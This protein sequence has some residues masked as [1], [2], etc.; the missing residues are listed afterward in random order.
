[1]NIMKCLLMI[2]GL[3]SIYFG[4]TTTIYT[5]EGEPLLVSIDNEVSAEQIASW[6]YY[7]DT[8]IVSLGL[9]AVR[10]GDASWVYNCHGYAWMKSENRTTCWFNA[11]P[12][13]GNYFAEDEDYSNDDDPSYKECSELIATHSFYTNCLQGHSTRKIQNSYPVSIVNGRDYVSKWGYYGLVQH[14]KNNDMFYKGD[15]LGQNYYI[16]KATHE[17]ALDHSPKTWVG[18]GGKT[19][20]ITN[21]LTVPSTVTLNIKE[22]V[23]VQFSS[24]KDMTISGTLISEEDITIPSGSILTVNSGAQ[25]KFDS[26]KKLIV[27]GTLNANGAS[28]TRSSTSGSWGGIQFNSG[29][30]GSLA[31]CQIRYADKGVYENGTT[32]NITNSAISNCTDGIYLY[33]SSPTI[34]G[35]NIHD[36][37]NGINMLYNSS[38]TVLKENYI[39]N[40]NVGIFCASGSNPIIGNNS[41]PQIGNQIS[42]NS[43]GIMIYNNALPVIGNGSSGGYNNLVNSGYNVYNATANTVYAYNNWWGTTNPA[44]FLIYGTVSYIPYRTTAVSVPSPSLSKTSENLSAS[45]VEDIPMLSELDKAYQLVA[46]NNLEEA[47]KICLNLVNNYPNYSVSY[48]ALNLL[49]DTYSGK[50]ITAK[51]D[52]YKSMFNSENKKD[53]YAMAGLILSDIDKENRLK[54]IDEVIESYEGESI[55]EL[56]LFDKFVYYYFEQDDIK[57]ARLVSNE[58]DA[59]FP[60]SIGAFE[61]HKILGDEEYLNS[62]IIINQSKI[63]KETSDE[64]VSEDFS[65]LGNYPNPFNPTTEI[66]FSLPVTSNVKLTI[67][68]MMGQ[69]I[70]T[71]E[72]NGISEGTHQ[73]T[74]NGTNKNN[75]QVSSGIYIYRL[76]AVGHDGQIFEKSAKMVLL[77]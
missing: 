46:S 17:D 40:N 11:T 3:T 7:I 21:D 53:L 63:Q 50:E 42:G 12:N 61:A 33:N 48:N 75:E 67:Y 51:N 28:F 70:K 18:A 23:T 38:S 9:N 62:D 69:E 8:L 5:P 10:I 35:C 16:L 6:N 20:T 39:Q 45:A 56:A 60:E 1:M 26:G 76:R 57:S 34:Q 37:N 19:H 54:H 4:G 64:K 47:R 59:Q 41:S 24:G 2:L 43:M 25:I 15:D 71:F 14:S 68:N 66:K 77:K 32:V 36:N 29:S 55:I 27:N 22:D 65:L 73:F 13:T 74:W 44:N 49:K 72:S 52:V 31:N 58:L 30:S